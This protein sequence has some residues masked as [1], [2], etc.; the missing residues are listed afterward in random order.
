MLPGILLFFSVSLSFCLKNTLSNV[1]YVLGCGQREKRRIVPCSCRN[2]AERQKKKK[3]PMKEYVLCVQYLSFWSGRVSVKTQFRDT[4]SK[5]NY[6]ATVPI[7]LFCSGTRTTLIRSPFS[8]P[9]FETYCA[10]CPDQLPLLNWLPRR[11]IHSSWRPGGSRCAL[12]LSCCL[13]ANSK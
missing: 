11:C 5:T 6:A 4:S 1:N 13:R 8:F 3:K 12:S 9:R 7:S 10:N 2:S